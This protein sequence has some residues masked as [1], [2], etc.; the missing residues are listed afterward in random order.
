MP[1]LKYQKYILTD[2]ILPEGAK[3]RQEIYSQRATHV[4]WLEDFIIKGAPSII[5]SW[6]WKP[7]VEDNRTP[8]H[9]HDFDEVLGF[10]GSDPQNPHEL[11]GEVELWMDD[12]KYTLDKTCLVYIPKG[13]RHCPLNITRVDKPLLFLAFSTTDKYIKDGVQK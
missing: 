13:L 6:Y 3:K 1:E 8:S 11:Y 7:S 10:F 9:T 4:L 2:L 5:F 12:E